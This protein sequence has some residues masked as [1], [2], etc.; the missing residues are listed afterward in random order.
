M[1]HPYWWELHLLTAEWADMSKQ[2]KTVWEL[3]RAGSMIMISSVS[4]F[5]YLFWNINVKD[6]T[7]MKLLSLH[8]SHPPSVIYTFY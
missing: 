1:I 7:L 8:L 3:E 6:Y 4:Q 5:K 2:T